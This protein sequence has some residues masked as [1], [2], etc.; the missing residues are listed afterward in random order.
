MDTFL[1]CH[2]CLGDK[3][4]HKGALFNRNTALWF[5]QFFSKASF[6]KKQKENIGNSYVIL[7]IENAYLLWVMCQK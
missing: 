2:F 1:S 7:E 5:F 6:K 4:N 3:V